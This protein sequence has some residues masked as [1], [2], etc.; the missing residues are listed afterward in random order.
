MASAAENFKAMRATLNEMSA[1]VDDM[2]A[3]LANMAAMVVKLMEKEKKNARAAATAR[4][5]PPEAS[6]ILPVTSALSTSL[7]VVAP[8]VLSPRNKAAAQRLSSPRARLT[9]CLRRC[10]AWQVSGPRQH[11]ATPRV[12][13]L[14]ERCG[15]SSMQCSVGATT[16]HQHGVS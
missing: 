7:L 9:S 14:L 6:L 4:S 15:P 2:K 16:S 1:G 12:V 3:I 13:C 11:C 10:G 5:A 8:T